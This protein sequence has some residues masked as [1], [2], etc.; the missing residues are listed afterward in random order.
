M[1]L[2]HRFISELN[3]LEQNQR[4]CGREITQQNNFLVIGTFNPDNNSCLR[5]NDASW[6]YGRK[7]NYF[8]EDIHIP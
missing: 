5:T 4:F 8:W 2:Y 1:Q 3:D 6:F 7:R